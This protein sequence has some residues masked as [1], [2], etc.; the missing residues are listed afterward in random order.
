MGDSA[1]VR[2]G[3]NHGL[4][5]Y[6]AVRHDSRTPNHSAHSAALDGTAD[7]RSGY[8]NVVKGSIIETLEFSDCTSQLYIPSQSFAELH[9]ISPW[10]NDAHTIGSS[11]LAMY[12]FAVNAGMSPSHGCLGQGLLSVHSP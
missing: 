9:S 1:T 10:F 12:A 6:R 2:Y 5:I 4:I 11:P 3:R 8:S 7:M